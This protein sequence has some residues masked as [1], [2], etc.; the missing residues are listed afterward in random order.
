MS[1]SAPPRIPSLSGDEYKAMLRMAE[2]L[3]RRCPSWTLSPTALVHEV[4]IKVHAWPGLPP[5]S[6]PHFM[7][8]AARAMRQVLVDAAR[9]K[10][11]VKKGGRLKFVPLT[12]RAQRTTL[13]PVEFLDLNQA[14]DELAK[15]NARH[16]FVVT[17]TSWFG[18]TIEEVAEMLKVS[19]KTVQRDLRAAN[20]WL[21]SR[22]SGTPEK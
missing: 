4:L 8:L 5:S 3:H 17:Y 15:M 1:Q 16:G 6:D 2:S 21:A 18:Y 7:A 20:A 10:L 9:K 14:M 12:E 22:V 13:S 11:E 19:T